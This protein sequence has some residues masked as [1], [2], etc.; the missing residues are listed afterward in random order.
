MTANP[1]F[2][3]VTGT[4]D[5]DYDIIWFTESCLSKVSSWETTNSPSSFAGRST[6]VARVPRRERSYWLS[7]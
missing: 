5:K 4:K 3:N 7:A 2:G 6:R 1:E